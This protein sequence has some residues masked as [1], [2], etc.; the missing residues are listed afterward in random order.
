ML[1]IS[2][3]ARTYCLHWAIMIS[4][5][6]AVALESPSGETAEGHAR[7]SFSLEQIQLTM[8]YMSTHFLEVASKDEPN[9]IV[10][11]FQGIFFAKESPGLKKR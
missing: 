10:L 8:W 7:T 3:R 4:A 11:I 2:T 9:L 1:I 5:D 6:I